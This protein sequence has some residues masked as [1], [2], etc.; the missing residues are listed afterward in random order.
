MPTSAGLQAARIP[1][2]RNTGSWRRG[3][4][5]SGIVLGRGAVIAVDGELGA[6]WLVTVERLGRAE[7]PRAFID[8]EVPRD[9]ARRMAPRSPPP[10]GCL[11]R[12]YPNR[13]RWDSE[14]S[15][16]LQGSPEMWYSQ[17]VRPAGRSTVNG[18]PKAM[19]PAGHEVGR[20]PGDDREVRSERHVCAAG[21]ERDGEVRLQRTRD[22][23]PPRWN[24]V[25][26]PG[27]TAAPR[28]SRRG[29]PRWRRRRADHEHVRIVP[30]HWPVSGEDGSGTWGSSVRTT[31]CGS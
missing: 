11:A 12:S 24:P 10:A 21:L 29:R 18:L 17:E 13:N 20:R 2:R 4:W 14:I 16:P 25:R 31:S 27:A 7:D 19:R 3:R 28:R 5:P 1:R 6:E 8:E 22:P 30:V 26:R 15:N 9:R 23:T